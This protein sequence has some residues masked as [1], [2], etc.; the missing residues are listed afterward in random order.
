MFG[1]GAGE[2]GTGVNGTCLP[3][4]EGQYPE[5]DDELVTRVENVMLG[6]T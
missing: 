3:C 4:T 1:C 6:N 5:A 2:A